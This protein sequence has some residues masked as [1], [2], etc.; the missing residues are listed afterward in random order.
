[1]YTESIGRRVDPMSE[2]TVTVGAT[3]GIFTTMQA[4]IEPGDEVVVFEPNYDSYIPSVEYLGGKVQRVPLKS[5]EP[6]AEA[7]AH[8]VKDAFGIDFD[9][10]EALVSNKTRAIILNNPHNPSGRCLSREEVARLAA[11]VSKINGTDEGT[12]TPRIIAPPGATYSRQTRSVPRAVRDRGGLIVV[13]DEV[14][15]RL[16]LRRPEGSEQPEH[17]TLASIPELVDHT[18]VIGSAGKT[19]SCTGWKVGWVVG[20]APIVSAVASVNQ[21]TQFCV[22]TPSQVAV[23]EALG[24][25][26][27]QPYEGH[28]SFLDWLRQ[29]YEAKRAALTEALVNSGFSAWV[30]DAGFFTLADTSKFLPHIPPKY[31]EEPSSARSAHKLGISPDWALCRWLT[32]EA[33]VAAIPPSAFYAFETEPLTAHLAR[34]AFCKTLP[35]IQEAGHR[36]ER[37]ATRVLRA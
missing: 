16:V 31:F 25:A 34:F 26:R 5:P 10:L 11:L 15:D 3:G 8:S 1:M 2:V 17:L 23:A 35:D 13:C 20:P 32:S 36:L 19:L 6:I 24:I 28:D 30:P 7:G 4:L 9:A 27:S 33:K 12:P 14:Y 37:F 29:D 18:V 21:W 22:S